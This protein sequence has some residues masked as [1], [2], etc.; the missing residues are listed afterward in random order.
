MYRE[1]TYVGQA[2][3][4]AGERRITPMY[5]EVTAKNDKKDNCIFNSC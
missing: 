1:T 4:L 5:R 3:K 2:I